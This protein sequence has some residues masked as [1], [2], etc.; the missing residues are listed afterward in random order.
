MPTEA[1]FKDHFYIIGSM[2]VVACCFDRAAKEQ[3]KAKQLEKAKKKAAEKPAAKTMQKG[4]AQQKL[5]AS[6]PRVGGKR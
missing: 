5:P 1:N 3:K 6:K 2:L 4:K